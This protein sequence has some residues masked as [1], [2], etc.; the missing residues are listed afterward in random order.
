[1]ATPD[2]D[3]ASTAINPAA[4]HDADAAA[5]RPSGRDPEEER[6]PV[7]ATQGVSLNPVD[8]GGIDE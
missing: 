7:K 4:R 8:Q 2:K 5:Q 1:M 3:K 6:R